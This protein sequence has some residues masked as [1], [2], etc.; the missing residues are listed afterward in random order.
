MVLEVRTE[1]STSYQ[2]NDITH[3][4]KR[5]FSGYPLQSGHNMIVPQAAPCWYLSCFFSITNRRRFEV[6]LKKSISFRDYLAS[7]LTCTDR[8]ISVL[9][10][11]EITVEGMSLASTCPITLL[12]LRYPAKGACCTHIEASISCCKTVRSDVIVF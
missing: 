1:I 10:D 12:P 9:E 5:T 3:S 6:G 7:L 11:D 8:K 2:L 4:G